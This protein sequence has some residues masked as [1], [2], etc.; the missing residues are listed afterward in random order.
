MFGKPRIRHDL[1]EEFEAAGPEIVRT[2][3]LHG[4]ANRV[5][6]AEVLEQIATPS[7]QRDQAFAWL[8]WKD[9]VYGRWIKTGVVAAVLAAIFSLL[10]LVK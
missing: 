4:W 5:G 7:E 6:L 2:I 1:R 10:A 8:K 9:A 3:L